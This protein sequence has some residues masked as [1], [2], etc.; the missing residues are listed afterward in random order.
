[1]T[2]HTSHGAWQ[3][4][5]RY[6][7]QLDRLFQEFLTVKESEGLSQHTVT[8]Y[9]TAVIGFFRFL[10][11][12]EIERCLDQFTAQNV[13]EWILFLKEKVCYSEHPV[14]PPQDRTLSSVSVRGYVV[15]VKAFARWLA[16]ESYTSGDRLGKLKAPKAAR[17][18]IQPPNPSEIKLVLASIDWRSA[19]GARNFAFVILVVD[20]GLRLSEATDLEIDD[21]NV[22][23]GSL[24]CWGKGRRQRQV[25][26]GSTCQ[27]ALL[28]WLNFRPYSTKSR[29]AVLDG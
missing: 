20:S 4:T 13:R 19:L 12:R 10:E 24:I 11:S 2:S 26:F 28:R 25:H 3:M 1:M 5:D 14:T 29:S 17:K 8:W 21:V 23:E 16:S 22:K 18:M 27:R 7:L 9:E 15:A 6:D